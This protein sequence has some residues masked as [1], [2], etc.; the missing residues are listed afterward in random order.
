M[1]FHACKS[2]LFLQALPLWHTKREHTQMAA[3][4]IITSAFDTG[5]THRKTRYDKSILFAL[6][7][8]A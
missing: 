8:S 7:V 5:E 4:P 3:Y 6:P 1:S 2:W